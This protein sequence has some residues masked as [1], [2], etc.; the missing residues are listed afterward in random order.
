MLGNK[1]LLDSYVWD[2]VMWCL[3]VQNTGLGGDGQS[4]EENTMSQHFGS[5]YFFDSSYQN[6]C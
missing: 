6:V 3:L 1:W 2:T 4:Y 5:K